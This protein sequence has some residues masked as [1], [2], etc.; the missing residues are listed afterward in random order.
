MPL[1]AAVSDT[2]SGGLTVLGL[3]ACHCQWAVALAVSKAELSL[4]V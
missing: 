4:R 2:A 3:R 1:P